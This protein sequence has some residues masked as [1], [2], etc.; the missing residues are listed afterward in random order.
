MHNPVLT[1]A[2]QNDGHGYSCSASDLAN[3]RLNGF[4][5]I[6]SLLDHAWVSSL[7]SSLDHAVSSIL[8]GAG[9][10]NQNPPISYGSRVFVQCFRPSEVCH[11]LRQFALGSAMGSVLKQL[12]GA[13]G[14][15]LWLDQALYKLPHGNPTAWHLDQFIWPFSESEGVTVWVA[16]DDALLSSGCLYYLP[17]THRLAVPL[18]PAV[19]N[20]DIEHNF[21]ALLDVYPNGSRLIRYRALLSRGC[22][23]P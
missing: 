8:Q 4:L 12:C 21:G 3:F 9:E 17:G 10:H 23:Y 14:M 6:P 2:S 13:P 16:L 11:E 18:R 7:R 19:A 15:R 22:D 20:L 5:K 1:N